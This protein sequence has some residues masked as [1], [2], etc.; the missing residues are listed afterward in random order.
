MR[1][2]GGKNRCF[3]KIINL[4]PPHRVYIETHLGSGAVLRHKSP[5][6]VN[7]GIDRDPRVLANF[8]NAPMNTRLICHRAEDFLAGYEFQGD[9]VIYCDPPY[10]PST[11]RRARVYRFDYTT[12][13]HKKLLDLLLGVRCRILLSGYENDLYSSLLAHW[14][15]VDFI[16]GTHAGNRVESLWLNYPPGEVHD[17]RYLGWTFHER[18]S[19]KRKRQRWVSRFEKEPPSIRQALIDDLIAS[20]Q[21]CST[22]ASH[23]RNTP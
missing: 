23:P 14:H 15:R 11:R 7:I 20:Q 12:E 3:Q 21:R 6:Q 13:E 19:V 2:A 4:I 9:E 8:K 17:T 1:I 10:F 16:D 22:Q 5:A 18:Q